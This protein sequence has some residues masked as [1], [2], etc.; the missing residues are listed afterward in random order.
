MTF[1]SMVLAVMTA[2]AIIRACDWL[3]RAIDQFAKDWMGCE[4][5]RSEKK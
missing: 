3:E 1:F 4:S 5:A 2:I